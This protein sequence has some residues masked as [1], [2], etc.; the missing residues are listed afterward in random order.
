MV[1]FGCVIDVVNDV[2]V[3]FSLL[4]KPFSQTF[5][6]PRGPDKV[7]ERQEPFNLAIATSFFQIV[8]IILNV[9]F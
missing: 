2:D 5:R 7:S 1:H 4:V 6:L 9:G 3:C 8:D